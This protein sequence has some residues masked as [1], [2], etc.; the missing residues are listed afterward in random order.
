M[1]LPLMSSPS[2]TNGSRYELSQQAELTAIKAAVRAAPAKRAADDA[3]RASLRAANASE[4]ARYAAMK[5]GAARAQIQA[6]SHA[7]LESPEC[8][9][10]RGG[11]MGG[12]GMHAT[13]AA[14]PERARVKLLPHA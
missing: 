10:G 4:A 12:A 6:R 2:P 9:A 14:A 13:Y 5:A 11:G 8:V 7:A 1:P 3:A